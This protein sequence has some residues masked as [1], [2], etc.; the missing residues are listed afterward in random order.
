MKIAMHEYKRVRVVRDITWT[1]Y[2]TPTKTLPAGW[3]GMI[4]RHRPGSAS[5]QL[6]NGGEFCVCDC[7]LEDG[8]VQEV[9]Q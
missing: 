3:E 1:N 7:F 8:S 2:N 6:E 4:T 9:A 5:A